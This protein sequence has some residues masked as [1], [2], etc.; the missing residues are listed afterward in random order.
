MKG[1]GGHSSEYIIAL[2][3]RCFFHDNTFFD[4]F[5]KQFFDDFGEAMI[6]KALVLGKNYL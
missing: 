6:L 1:T 3:K 2:L 4:K 5:L